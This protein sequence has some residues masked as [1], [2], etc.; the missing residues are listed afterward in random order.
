MRLFRALE[1]R[2]YRRYFTGQAISLVG[3]WMTMTT[4]GWLVYELTHDVRLLGIV[5]FSQQIPLLIVSPLAGA[6][7]DRVNRRKLFC[8]LQ[9][10]CM[11]HSGSLAALTLTGHLTA[12]VLVALALYRGIVNA[13]EFPTRQTLMVELV[14]RK[15]NLPNAIALNSTLF[16]VARLIGPTAAGFAIAAFCPHPE[17]STR[18][19]GGCY[20]IDALSGVP[21][22]ALM[23]SIR[24]GGAARV[25][26]AAVK[27]FAA[28]REGVRYVM[29]DRALVSPLAIISVISFAGF[30]GVTL[31]PLIARELLHGGPRTLGA[32]HTSVGLGALGS[33]IF[34]GL[35]H[36]H[37]G[38][39]K[40]VRAGVICVVC[41]QSL[42]A[43]SSHNWTTFA[44][45]TVCGMGTVLVFAG[46][47][48]LLQARVDD[49]KRGRVMGLFAMCQSMYPLGGLFIG[50]LASSV[51]GPRITMMVT[52]SLCLAGAIWFRRTTEPRAEIGNKNGE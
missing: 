2:D 26:K 5:V 6:L 13:T 15:E 47:N 9:C 30:A 7:G 51:L 43:V 40:W 52:A 39:E 50:L 14:G 21:V 16:N 8:V 11:L 36:T 41:G 27:P 31:A 46:S 32:L 3:D 44:G 33:A 25:A 10:L 20:A 48:T 28:V 35:R 37:E 42:V 34:L 45:M 1:S 4:T 29:T 24:D 12:H 22:V 38:L 19:A 49:D 18:G 23:L 17:L